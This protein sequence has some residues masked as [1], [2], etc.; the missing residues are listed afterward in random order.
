MSESGSP[1]QLIHIGNR[2]TR[3][4]VIRVISADTS[5][6]TAYVP[7]AYTAAVPAQIDPYLKRKLCYMTMGGAS[8]NSQEVQGGREREE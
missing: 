4:T 8:S 2:Y 1:E 5:Q 7:W 3:T 6:G